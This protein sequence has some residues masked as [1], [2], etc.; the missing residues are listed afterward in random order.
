MGKN[1]FKLKIL[2]QLLH[3][4]IMNIKKV[5]KTTAGILNLD[6]HVLFKCADGHGIYE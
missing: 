1:L 6:S 3:D 5:S 2:K 4:I